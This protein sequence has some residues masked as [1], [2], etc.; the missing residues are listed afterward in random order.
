MDL[1]ADLPCDL[2]PDLPFALPQGEGY[3]ASFLPELQGWRLQVPNGLLLY[4][5]HFFTPDVSDRGL[6]FLQDYEGGD[7][8]T[9]DWCS[10]AGA[11]LVQRPFKNIAWEQDH[12]KMYGKTIPLPRLTAW[13][14]DAGAAYTYSGIKSEPKPWNKGLLYMKA[15][16][17]KACQDAAIPAQFNSVL[18][19][20]Y[21]SG[22]DYLVAPDSSITH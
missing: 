22:E 6:A 18:L 2:P 9:T 11:E 3:A 4:V 17:E 16:I 8:R 14:G 20:W 10:M 12:I 19:N 7:W 21:R 15:Q 1:F 5:P 13:Y